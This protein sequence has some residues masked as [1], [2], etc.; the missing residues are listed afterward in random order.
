MIVPPDEADAALMA[1]RNHQ[2]GSQAVIIGR[3]EPSPAGRVLLQ[4]LIG[5]TR[6]LDMLSGEMLPRIC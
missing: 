6:I 1:M 2:Y 4:T 3:V 5:G